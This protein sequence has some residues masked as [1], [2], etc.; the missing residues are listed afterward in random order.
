MRLRRYTRLSNGFSKEVENLA[1]AVS[2]HVM[3]DNF[4]RPHIT[5]TKDAEGKKTRDIAALID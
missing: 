1:H 5:L 4:A 3:N 2:L